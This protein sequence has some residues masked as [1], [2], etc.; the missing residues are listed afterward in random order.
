MKIC[1]HP[2]AGVLF[3]RFAE[4]WNEQVTKI[5]NLSLIK[6][7][8]AADSGSSEEALHTDFDLPSV[9]FKTC[10]QDEKGETGQ[11]GL[12]NT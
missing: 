12:D 2:T 3:A 4:N 5:F 10:M 8:S 9:Y 1:L 6:L 11:K 7:Q